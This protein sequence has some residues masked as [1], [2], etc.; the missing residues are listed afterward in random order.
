MVIEFDFL[1]TFYDRGVVQPTVVRV[2]M[3]CD[4][5]ED[6]VYSTFK[7]I[8]GTHSHTCILSLSL[9][10]NPRLGSFVRVF[11]FERMRGRRIWLRESARKDYGTT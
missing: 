3:C 7:S 9:S 5:C 8:K 10:E 6:R 4:A 2:P 11:P 1:M